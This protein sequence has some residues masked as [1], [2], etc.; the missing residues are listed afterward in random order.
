MGYNEI[1]IE[2]LE[3]NLRLY[4]RF[5]DSAVFLPLDEHVHEFLAKYEK[6]WVQNGENQEPYYKEVILAILKNKDVLENL[7]R[8]Y[9]NPN[10]SLVDIRAFKNEKIAMPVT[11]L[12]D[13]TM[14]FA[15]LNE[16][17]SLSEEEKA[18]AKPYL[19]EYAS[20]L[21]PRVMLEDSS[22]YSCTMGNKTITIP[23]KK[24]AKF[25]TD[26]YKNARGGD[27]SSFATDGY[28]GSEFLFAVKSWAR[29]DNII[30]RYIFDPEAK[31]VFSALERDEIVDFYGVDKLNETNNP[32]TKGTK[33]SPDITDYVFSSMPANFSKT[34]K[35]IYAYIKLCRCLQ[36]DAGFYASN[37]QGL[38]AD[39][40]ADKSNLDNINLEN[41]E[42]VCYEFAAIYGEILNML[43][44]NYEY[45]N[46]YTQYGGGHADLVFKSDGFVVE[47]EPLKSIL[48]SDFCKAR[49]DEAVSGLN[50]LNSN[51]SS[52]EAFKRAIYDVSDYIRENE[53]D[54]TIGSE[55][56]LWKQQYDQI[57]DTKVEIPMGEKFHILEK[58]MQDV[59]D[60]NS[61]SKLIYLKRICDRMFEQERKQEDFEMIILNEQVESNRTSALPIVLLVFQ[62]K[63]REEGKTK[64]VKYGYDDTFSMLSKKQLIEKLKTKQFGFINESRAIPGI[65]DEEILGGDDNG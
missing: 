32:F 21:D 20:T 29:S 6:K 39:F 46:L 16:F 13:S 38:A 56:N 34:E 31:E 26:D 57:S 59:K 37:Q 50:P 49:F 11:R 41:N 53:P 35:A 60:Y 48:G 55:F 1:M 18:T 23:V 43:N 7:R 24:L 63:N 4:E 5:L 3:R 10:S 64:Y 61:I 19:D 54:N 58:Q 2:E 15:L 28:S 9:L 45:R 30:T 25:L 65:D 12:R 14:L 42:V 51:K 47:A 22:E 8:V 40:H 36:Y 52:Q 17:E 27:I 44:I 33:V 62:P